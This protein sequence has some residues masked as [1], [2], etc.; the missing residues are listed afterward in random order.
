MLCEHLCK[1]QLTFFLGRLQGYWL[2][3]DTDLFVAPNDKLGMLRVNRLPANMPKP[4][5]YKA[6]EGYAKLPCN[7]NDGQQELSVIICNYPMRIR[8]TCVHFTRNALQHE[9]EHT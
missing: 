8:D 2:V 3:K 1:I 5:P 9:D 4:P 6:T 7:F